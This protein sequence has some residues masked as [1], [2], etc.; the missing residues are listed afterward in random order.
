[1][2]STLSFLM[3]ILGLILSIKELVDI[4][5]SYVVADSIDPFQTI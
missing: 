1:M 3:F 5:V 4:I 2:M